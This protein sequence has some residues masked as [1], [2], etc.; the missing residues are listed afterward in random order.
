MVN[1]KI[2]FEEEEISLEYFSRFAFGIWP[3]KMIAS[4][5]D[6]KKFT[7]FRCDISR[8]DFP[9]T[10]TVRGI[11][12]LTNYCCVR[13][14]WRAIENYTSTPACTGNTYDI[15]NRIS[16]DEIKIKNKNKLI[17]QLVKTTTTTSLLCHA[18]WFQGFLQKETLN[19]FFNRYIF[20][21]VRN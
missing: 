18:R 14:F 19:F 1:R 21:L 17:C 5:M 12:W 9:R 16:S 2:F 11:E 8:I 7:I 13:K 6:R 10:I 20:F 15:T 4:E 3:S